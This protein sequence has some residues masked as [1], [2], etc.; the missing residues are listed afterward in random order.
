MKFN[1]IT[2]AVSLLA[3]TAATP[4]VAQT[5]STIYKSKCQMCHMADGSGN[6]AMKVPSFSP[7]ASVESLV[8]ITKKG[9]SPRMPSYAGKLTDA[10]IKDVATYIK[11]LK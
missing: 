9:I 2:I 1:L 10:Q 11:T 4:M 3:V 8:A 6:K 5:G 7:S